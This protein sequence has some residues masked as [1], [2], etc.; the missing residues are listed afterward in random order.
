MDIES[1]EKMVRE[2][3]KESGFTQ[4]DAAAMCNVGV[5]FLSELENGKPT[6]QIGK[7]LHVLDSF[8]LEIVVGPRRIF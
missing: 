7:V 8:G 6:L 3:R 5:R 1:I 4:A 2:K